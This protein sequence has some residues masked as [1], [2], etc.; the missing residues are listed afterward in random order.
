MVFTD[1]NMQSSHHNRLNLRDTSAEPGNIYGDSNIPASRILRRDEDFNDDLNDR[2]DNDA[3]DL[4]PPL[5][6]AHVPRNEL[7]NRAAMSGS[8]K[9]KP[10][11]AQSSNRFAG[12]ANQVL[13]QSNSDV[14]FQTAAS[15]VL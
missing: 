3:E 4:P 13:E 9:N 11:H 8:S 5:E 14:N 10:D 1:K 7:R 2:A 6:T 12:V 15:N